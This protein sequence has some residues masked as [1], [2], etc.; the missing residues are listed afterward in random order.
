M[1]T[2]LPIAAAGCLA[3][4]A[5][6]AHGGV[7]NPVVLARMEGMTSLQEA[8]AVIGETAKG[9]RTFDTAEIEAAL[10]ELSEQA[11]Q[12]PD[13]FETEASDPKSEALPVSWDV[14]SDFTAR[15]NDLRAVSASLVAAVTSPADL[16]G[17]LRKV[18]ETCSGC[19][20]RYR[21]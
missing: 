2:I 11:A 15:A 8:L 4:T 13:Q 19:H 16:P 21:E 20:E 12:I 14:F 10:R 18:G 3:A 5:L 7:N 6:L 9:E 17:A 1:K